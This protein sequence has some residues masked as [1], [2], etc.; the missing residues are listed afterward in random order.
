[1]KTTSTAS[2]LIVEDEPRQLRYYTKTLRR[3][4]LNCVPNGTAALAAMAERIPDLIILD[5]ILAGGEYGTDFLPRLK[6][7]AAHVPVIIISGTL[8]I[9][10]KLAALQGPL[11]AHYVL[12]KPVDLDELDAT[13]E[14]ALSECG[15][16][17]TVRMLRALENAEKIES[18]DPERRFTERLARQHS[19][20]NLLR[21]SADKPNISTLARDFN[22]SRKTIRRDLCDLIQRGQLDAAVYPEWKDPEPEEV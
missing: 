2:I 17:E 6:A 19:L 18:N 20:I 10:G 7:L 3:Y 14:K 8:E 11:A 9:A 1:V 16:G 21:K 5:H 12:E 22:V 13:V 15:L 4:Q